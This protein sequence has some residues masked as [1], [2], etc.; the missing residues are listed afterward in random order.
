MTKNTT[1]AKAYYTA[2]S[3]K[4]IK[5]MGKYL[6]PDVRLISPLS[7]LRGKEAYLEALKGFTSF[8]KTLTVRTVFGEGDQAVVICDVLCPPSIGTLPT[9]ILMTLQNGLITQLE[10]FH[11]TAPLNK[12]T[13]DLLA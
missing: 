11:D 4:N 6:H 7:Q 12:A 13:A 8:F 3:E 9:A 5:V 10:L 1:I 2:M